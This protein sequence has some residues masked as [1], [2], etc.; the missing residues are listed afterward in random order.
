MLT[1]VEKNVIFSLTTLYSSEGREEP[2]E[3]GAEP[4]PACT[5]TILRDGRDRRATQL[6]QLW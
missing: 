4:C 5:T 3:P 2:E 6:L 1:S